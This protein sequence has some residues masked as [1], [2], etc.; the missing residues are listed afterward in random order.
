MQDFK[1]YKNVGK[2]PWER[3]FSYFL[4]KIIS[5]MGSSNEPTT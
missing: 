3:N 2:S 4:N 1:E 5:M